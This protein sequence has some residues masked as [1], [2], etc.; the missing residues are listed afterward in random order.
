MLGCFHKMTG[1]I[2]IVLNPSAFP[3]GC[4][5]KFPK[6]FPSHNMMGFPIAALWCYPFPQTN[7]SLGNGMQAGCRE[8][9][10]ICRFSSWYK[11]K[12]RL[13]YCPLEEMEERQWLKL[14]N[15]PKV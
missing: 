3:F 5:M 9:E 4:F 12:L 15:K 14:P 7:K 10:D 1:I 2:G 6:V 13:H 8:L 11:P